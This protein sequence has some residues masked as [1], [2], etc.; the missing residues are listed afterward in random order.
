MVQEWR[1]L[2]MAK[3]SGRAH[4]PGG[5]KATSS[6]GFTILCRACPLPDVNLPAD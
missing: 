3:R 6:G 2:K 5:I 1:H 4:D